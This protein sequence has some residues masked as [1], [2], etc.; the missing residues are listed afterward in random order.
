MLM[1]VIGLILEPERLGKMLLFKE[2]QTYVRCRRETFYLR[3]L[4][5]MNIIALCLH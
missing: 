4:N 1:F 3:T 5:M 2:M